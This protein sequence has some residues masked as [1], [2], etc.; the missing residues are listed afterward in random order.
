MYLIGASTESRLWIFFQSH[1]I[2]TGEGP[3]GSLLEVESKEAG[4]AGGV[5]E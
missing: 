3:H 2:R 4:V 5:L 1:G